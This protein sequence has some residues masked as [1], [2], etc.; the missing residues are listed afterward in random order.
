MPEKKSGENFE[1]LTG[2]LIVIAVVGVSFVLPVGLWIANKFLGWQLPQ[3]L[4]DALKFFE[5]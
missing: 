2:K 1:S 4:Q 5:S 3:F